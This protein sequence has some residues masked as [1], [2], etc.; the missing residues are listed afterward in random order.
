MFGSKK[1]N[2]K[3]LEKSKSFEQWCYDNLSNKQATEILSKWDYELNKRK[4]SDVTFMS[5]GL[6]KKGYWFKCLKHPE[7]KSELKSISTF[8][9]GFNQ[10]GT[11]GSISC[12]QC[13]S[14]AMYLINTYGDNA[15]DLY[16]DW[17]K[18]NESSIN[19][20]EIASQY[21]KKVW[22]KCQEKDYHL[23]YEVSCNDFYNGKRCPYCSRNGGK[24]H[25]LDSLGQYIINNYGQEFLDKIWGDKNKKSP[26][27]YSI[28][29]N[30]KVWFKCPD[31]KHDDYLRTIH[32]SN[33]YEFRCISCINERKESFLQEKIRLY[34]ESLEYTILHEYNCTIVPKNPKTK[35]SGGNNSLPYDNEIKELKLIIECHGIQHYELGGWHDLQS[36][37]NNTTPEYELYYQQLKDR[38]KRMYAKSQGYNYLEIPYW[39]DDKERTWRKLIDDKINEILKQNK[40]SA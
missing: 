38:Y 10:S 35:N 14:F 23:S 25:P 16:W 4:P 17:E 18:N 28:G 29:S 21:N 1:A 5:N 31:G 20:W 19:P 8:V 33:S 13:N 7:H 3:N 37:T 39:V 34:L 32:N 15:L 36:K 12:K 11:F 2:K 40:K 9:T 22:I 27:K 6:N 24:L 26:Y 30:K